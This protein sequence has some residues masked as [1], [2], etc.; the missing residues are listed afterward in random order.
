MAVSGSQLRRLATIACLVMGAFLIAHSINAFV[1]DALS[2]PPNRPSTSGAADL[3][4]PASYVP[5]QSADDIRSSG[6]FVLPVVPLGVTN[7]P[8]MVSGTPVRASIGAAAKI[9]LIGVVFGDQRGV[10]AIVEELSSKRQS[11]YRLHQEIPDVGEVS[12]IRRDGMVVRLGDQAELL[13]LAL[14]E[15]PGP[16]AA[17]PGTPQGQTPGTPLRKV[18][19]RREVE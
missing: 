19:D 2:V 10:F 13:E 5:S 18:I 9:R 16:P 6:L 4:L 14:V 1:A 11:L 15:K 7:A 17:G 3:A 12:E 8:G